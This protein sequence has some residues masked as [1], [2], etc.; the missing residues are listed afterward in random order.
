MK[1]LHFVVDAVVLTRVPDV[2]LGAVHISIVL[3]SVVDADTRNV[4]DTRQFNSPPVVPLL[5]FG[6]STCCLLPISSSSR[7]VGDTTCSVV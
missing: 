3:F 2:D 7:R 6:M 4:V 5:G 1:V